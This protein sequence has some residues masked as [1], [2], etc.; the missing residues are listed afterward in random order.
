MQF[1]IGN[2]KSGLVSTANLFCLD[3]LKCFLHASSKPL[4]LPAQAAA[5]LF[6]KAL[7]C[8]GKP[9]TF[10]PLG[11]PCCPKPHPLC[12]LLHCHPAGN[13]ICLLLFNTSSLHLFS[14][15]FIGITMYLNVLSSKEHPWKIFLLH[16]N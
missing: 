1:F 12:S 8:P 15:I 11:W 16:G 14:I 4:S 10:V 3:S 13:S 6:A 5:T 2:V 9:R 7:I